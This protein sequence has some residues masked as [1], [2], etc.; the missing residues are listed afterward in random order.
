MKYP[1]IQNYID[2]KFVSAST[3][4]TMDVIS[5]LDGNHLS[6]VPMSS[7]KDLDDAVKA[8]QAAF[9]TWSKTPIFPVQIPT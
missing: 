2:G 6:T 8:A 7:R 4:K 3:S 9:P 1:A 5:P